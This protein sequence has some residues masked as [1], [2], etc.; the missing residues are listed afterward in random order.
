MQAQGMSFSHVMAISNTFLY[1]FTHLE[2]HKMLR[3]CLAARML[4]T[5]KLKSFSRKE[6]HSTKIEEKQGVF[7]SYV[8]SI[9]RFSQN[10]GDVLVLA[11]STRNLITTRN[12]YNCYKPKYEDSQKQNKWMKVVKMIL[13]IMR[14]LIVK[15]L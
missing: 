5:V 15:E 10:I 11:K 1:T 7:R 8:K 14:C 12:V 13:L 6:K 2:L 3:V 4:C 9:Q